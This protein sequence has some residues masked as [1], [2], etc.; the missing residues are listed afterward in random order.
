[1]QLKQEK[2]KETK[3]LVTPIFVPTERR[4][5]THT[6]AVALTKQES[7]ANNKLV[8]PSLEQHKLS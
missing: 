4:K 1:M 3:Q 2:K 8:V 5:N 6:L 7:K